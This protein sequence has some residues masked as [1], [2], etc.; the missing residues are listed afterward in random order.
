VLNFAFISNHEYQS[1]AI[2]WAKLIENNR[3]DTPS[4]SLLSR[5]HGIEF[6]VADDFLSEA[7]APSLYYQEIHKLVFHIVDGRRRRSR[8][9]KPKSSEAPPTDTADSTAEYKEKKESFWQ[10]K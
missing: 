4:K 6:L 1:V 3:A 8:S 9:P 7:K 10:K 2:K 5:R